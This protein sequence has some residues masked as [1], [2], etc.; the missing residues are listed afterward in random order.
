[1]KLIVPMRIAMNINAREIAATNA[2]AAFDCQRNTRRVNTKISDIPTEAAIMERAKLSS[3]MKRSTVAGARP[4]ADATESGKAAVVS[5]QGMAGPWNAAMKS[6]LFV[7]IEEVVRRIGEMPRK[8][9][10]A[11]FWM[12]I[13]EVP[14]GAWGL[15]G[16]AVSIET[17]A[18][19]FA[20]DRRQRIEEHLAAS[21]ANTV[22]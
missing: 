17:L 6:E 20:E 2:R 4:M 9:A 14:E 1:M 11:D 13:V 5:A 3:P 7:K 12:T 15:G 16:R 21:R 8:G 10:G 18:P 19:V 22:P